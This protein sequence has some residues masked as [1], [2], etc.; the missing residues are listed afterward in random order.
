MFTARITHKQNEHVRQEKRH[1]H[2]FILILEPTP[3]LCADMHIH[4]NIH[5]RCLNN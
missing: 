3:T 1:A 4:A 5:M 2:N